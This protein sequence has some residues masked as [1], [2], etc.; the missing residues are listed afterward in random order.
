M[1]E[2]SLLEKETTSGHSEQK[3]SSESG[4]RKIHWTD[5]DLK[6]VKHVFK[7]DIFKDKVTLDAVRGG[8]ERHKKLRGMSPRGVY[9]KL[10]KE[11]KKCCKFVAV[12]EPPQ[13]HE[14]LQ[15]KLD[16]MEGVGNNT[17]ETATNDDQL[18]TTIIPPSERN[19]AFRCDKVELIH[20]VLSDMISKTVT[21]SQRH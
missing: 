11:C 5:D 21:I 2:T 4:S 7:D 6:K 9:D 15:D 18:S 16:R 14:S 8:I 3:E 10:K 20:K 17:N 13:E 12:R 1:M 19:R